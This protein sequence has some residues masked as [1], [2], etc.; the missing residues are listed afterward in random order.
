MDPQN[1]GSDPGS[2]HELQ[3]RQPASERH[4]RSPSRRPHSRRPDSPS[5]TSRNPTPPNDAALQ[6]FATLIKFFMALVSIV[7]TLFAILS[8]VASWK[9]LDLATKANNFTLEANR[10]ADIANDWAYLSYNASLVQIRL[11]LMQ[12][13]MEWGNIVCIPE[14][15]QTPT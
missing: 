5:S 13:C 9:A 11:S 6:A 2:I 15:R 12:F 1:Q 10:K 3:T 8:V 7:G 14:P 4:S